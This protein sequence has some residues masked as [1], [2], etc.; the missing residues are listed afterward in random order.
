MQGASA[1][2]PVVRL[3]RLRG[4]PILEQLRLEE[5]LLRSHTGNWFVINDGAA[6]PAVVLGISGCAPAAPPPAPHSSG[7]A[8]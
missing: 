3:L 2:P 7:I 4:Y 5:A 1:A 8:A 6:A